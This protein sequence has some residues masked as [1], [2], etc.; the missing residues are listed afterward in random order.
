MTEAEIERGSLADAF[1]GS[2]GERTAGLAD[3]L[4]SSPARSGAPRKPAAKP[5]PARAPERAPVAFVEAPEPAAAA[6]GTSVAPAPA[7]AVSAPGKD[8]NKVENVAT[9]IEPAVLDV[10]KTMKRKMAPA[11]QPDLTYDELLLDA[12]DELGVDRIR[13]EFNPTAAGGDGLI[14]RRQRRVRGTGGVQIQLR[15]SV[16]QQEQ[17]EALRVEVGAASRSAF[18]TTVYRLAYV[19]KR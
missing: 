8:P 5:S 18:C 14:A 7:A 10:V 16:A 1:K 13:E 6:P 19:K 2:G 17:L 3:I 9:Y 15:L 4:A 12:I 11:G